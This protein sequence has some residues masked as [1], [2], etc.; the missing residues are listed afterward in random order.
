MRLRYDE[1]AGDEIQQFR[2]TTW[3]AAPLPLPHPFFVDS[4][5]ALVDDGGEVVDLQRKEWSEAELIQRHGE[6]VRSLIEASKSLDPDGILRGAQEPEYLAQGL[7]F[8]EVYLELNAVDLED[9]DAIVAFCRKYGTLGIHNRVWT[10]TFEGHRIFG[11]PGVPGFDDFAA[12]A[13][14]EQRDEL[15]GE[16]SPRETLSE[17]LWGA[18][19]VRDMTTAWKIESGQLSAEDAEWVAPCW[20]ETVPDGEYS[21]WASSYFALSR[22]MQSGL[23]PFGPTVH[24]EGGD[25]KPRPGFGGA[26]PSHRDAHLP[27]YAVLCLELFNH[28]CEGA[29]YRLCANETCGRQFVRQHGRAAHGQHRSQ[30]VMYCSARCARAQAQRRYRLRKR[31]AP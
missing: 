10:A 12:P 28:I 5:G 11:F 9:D 25:Q 19:C 13:L 3:P 16:S 31:P 22:G 14:D 26:H 30:G 18:Q 24:W 29:T 8:G 15:I 17:F 4:F 6:G 2:I 7:S 27:L 21:F 1:M 20:M 23:A